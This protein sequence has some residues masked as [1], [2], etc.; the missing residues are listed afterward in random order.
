MKPTDEGSSPLQLDFAYKQKIPMPKLGLSLGLRLGI[1]LGLELRLGPR[2]LF[3]KEIFVN[4]KLFEPE[5]PTL[6]NVPDRTG[7]FFV[8]WPCCI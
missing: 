3:L 8:H 5:G 6:L 7:G 1:S 4:I 2:P